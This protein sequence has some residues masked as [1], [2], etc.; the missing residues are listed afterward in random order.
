MDSAVDSAPGVVP[1]HIRLLRLVRSGNRSAKGAPSTE[2]VRRV[3]FAGASPAPDSDAD[4]PS[5]DAGGAR[6]ESRRLRDIRRDAEPEV[7]R[8][9]GGACDE[10]PDDLCRTDRHRGLGTGIAQ[11][12]GI[13]RSVNAGVATDRGEREPAAKSPLLLHD[14]AGS[15]AG[16]GGWPTCP[17]P[18]AAGHGPPAR[19]DWHACHEQLVPA[20]IR[21]ALQL[22]R[23]RT[24]RS[25]VLR[26]R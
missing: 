3:S 1:S 12:T 5:A 6:G 18:A 7:R 14:D 15:R 22:E 11:R 9:V 23:A 13:R 10:W 4:R 20:G 24:N 26:P 8:T 21:F 19:D 16:A 17:G 25:A 2:G